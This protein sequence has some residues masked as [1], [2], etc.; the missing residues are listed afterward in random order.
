MRRRHTYIIVNTAD[1]QAKPHATR[2]DRIFKLF[3]EIVNM[4]AESHDIFHYGMAVLRELIERMGKSFCDSNKSVDT[5]TV[6]K[7][8]DDDCRVLSLFA[9]QPKGMPPFKYKVSKVDVA[10]KWKESIREK[11]NLNEV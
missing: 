6:A 8:N 9:V 4:E 2:F 7:L 3:N 11:V 5:P 1:L 10:V